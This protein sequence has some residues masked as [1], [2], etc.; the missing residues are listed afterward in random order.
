MRAIAWPFSHD[1]NHQHHTGFKVFS[2]LWTISMKLNCSA[3]SYQRGWACVPCPDG[4]YQPAAGQSAC[5][6]CPY[7]ALTCTRLAFTCIE[8][9]SWDSGTNEC[10]EL[11]A[12]CTGS[13]CRKP[14]SSRAPLNF[15]ATN[16]I[17]A[18][19]ITSVGILSVFLISF[20]AGFTLED[21]WTRHPMMTTQLSTAT[22]TS[23]FSSSIDTSSTVSTTMFG[24]NSSQY[25]FAQSTTITANEAHASVQGPNDTSTVKDQVELFDFSTIDSALRE[26]AR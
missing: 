17:A 19:L 11:G 1:I 14:P 25:Q 16:P 21:R 13:D 20:V 2:D 18:I 23:T 15:W 5:L 24:N 8:H 12:Q 6:P 22:T 7:N 3:G 4:S 10:I 9:F 26:R